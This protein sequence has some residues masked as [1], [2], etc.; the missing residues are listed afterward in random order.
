ETQRGFQFAQQARARPR[1]AQAPAGPGRGHRTVRKIGG[2]THARPTSCPTVPDE[3]SLEGEKVFR[4]GAGAQFVVDGPRSA[5]TIPP[6]FLV[7]QTSTFF[8][9]SENCNQRVWT[10]RTPG[11][12]RHRRAGPDRPRGG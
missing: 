2:L 8:Y 7:N 5:A 4:A 1:P 10:H 9:G 11:L 12:P 3:A 6:R